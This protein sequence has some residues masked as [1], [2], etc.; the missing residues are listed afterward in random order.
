MN[1][2]TRTTRALIT[3]ILGLGLFAHTSVSAQTCD[4]IM[5]QDAT[6]N[7]LVHPEGYATCDPGTL[8]HVE[9]AGVG[10]RPMILIPGFG[11]GADAYADFMAER[12]TDFTMYAV[13]L[14]G[15]GGTS[16]PPMPAEGTSYG[17]LTW[18]KTAQ[19]SI[20]KLMENEDLDDVI[21]VGHWL[22]GTQLALWL[23][24]EHAERVSGV[25]IVSG[26]TRFTP[27][28]TTYFPYH[29]PLDFR[30]AGIDRFMAPNWFK[31]VTRETW[32]DNNFLPEH[33]AANPVRGL[34][35]WREAAAPD[36]HVWVRY[37]CEFSAQDVSLDLA[38]L[39]VPTLVL[40][41]GLEGIYTEPGQDFM[42]A[43]C[44][45]GWDGDALTNKHIQIESI[46]ES[47]LFIW[48]DQPEAFDE[49]FDGFVASLNGAP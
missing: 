11:F 1:P 21:L 41:P 8:G 5:V 31:T 7:N 46:P 6:L 16:A 18:L 48:Y 47:R 40:Q 24:L 10:A 30:V 20:S 36:L 49:H 38:Q 3:L 23:A 29:P 4:R 26:S 32:D 28:D 33:Y 9:K 15:F 12:I 22:G 42:K 17:E 2:G 39:S 43:Y 25:V 19:E 27:T 35:L 14:P 45:L 37:L 13:T 34:R 44:I